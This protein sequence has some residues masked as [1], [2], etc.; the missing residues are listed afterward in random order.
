MRPFAATVC[1]TIIPIFT[2]NSYLLHSR[3]QNRSQRFTVGEWPWKSL[4][5]IRQE[6]RY[7]TVN[8]S[9]PINVYGKHVSVLRHFWDNTTL[10]HVFDREQFLQLCYVAAL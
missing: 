10:Y 2:V 5:V 1:E 6:W 3:L 4:K 7:Q 8:I 9:L